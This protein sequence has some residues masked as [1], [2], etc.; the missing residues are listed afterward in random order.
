MIKFQLLDDGIN[1]RRCR[2]RHIQQIVLFIIGILRGTGIRTDTN[3]LQLILRILSPAFETLAQQGD[4]WHHIQHQALALRLVLHDFE[5]GIRLTSTTRHNH[6]ASVMIFEVFVS[7]GQ[8]INLVWAHRFACKQ[9]LLTLLAFHKFR[10]I[11]RRILKIIGINW[12][13]LNSLVLDAFLRILAPMRGRGNP[14]QLIE[15][16]CMHFIIYKLTIGIRYE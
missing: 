10:P 7:L 14:K 11:Y 3:R 15:A 13:K 5:R 12:Y 9:S 4:A 2:E 6:L 8:R 16:I 1:I